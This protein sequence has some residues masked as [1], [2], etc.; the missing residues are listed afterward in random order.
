METFK[1]ELPVTD[2][3]IPVPEVP[4]PPLLKPFWVKLLIGWGILLVL[5]FV[6]VLIIAPRRNS[7]TTPPIGSTASPVASI[8][9]TSSAQISQ[10]GQSAEFQR[11]EGTLNELKQINSSMDLNQNELAFPLLDY[12]VSFD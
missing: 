2:A 3:P 8:V 10:I 11:F 7:Q 6:I 9:A 4:R 1:K 12:E 5:V